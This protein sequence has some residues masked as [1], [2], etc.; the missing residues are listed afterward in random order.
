MLQSSIFQWHNGAG[1]LVLSGGGDFT[2]GETE[3]IDAR[4]LTRS[5]ADGALVVIHAA[6]D[7]PTGA[8]Q[9]LTYLSDLG[10]RSG[11]SVDIVTEDDDTIKQ[12]LGEAGMIVIS[13][14]PNRTQLFNSLHGAAIEGI[15]Q[16]YARGALVMGNGIGAAVFGQW[17]LGLPA[18]PP[19]DGFGW[20]AN[21]AVLAAPLQAAEKQQLQGLLHSTPTAFGLGIWPGSALVLGPERQVELWGRQQIS[22]SLGQAYSVQE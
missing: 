19:A 18:S 14:G 15:T 10:G 12:A 1:W 2:T 5:A 3:A 7:D 8:E 16:A 9:Y 22:I 4:M 20:L 21:S 6:A 13:D 11:Y 17:V